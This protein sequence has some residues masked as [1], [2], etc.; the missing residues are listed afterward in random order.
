[1]RVIF[2]FGRDGVRAE[3][4]DGEIKRTFIIEREQGFEQA[5]FGGGLQAITRFGF[6][7]G[8]A[9]REHAQQARTG[10]RDE[11]FHAGGARGFDS[12]NNAAACRENI[13]I[14]HAAHL[15]LEFVGAV[16]RPDEMR[17]RVDKAG[18]E[19]ATARVESGFIGIGVFE[20]SGGA[21]RDDLFIAHND[22]AVFDDAK[23]AEGM[24][25]LRAACEGEELGGGVDE[26]VYHQ[27]I[28]YVWFSNLTTERFI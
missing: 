2:V 6:G 15:H 14:G 27:W 7:G 5:Q 21:D 23:R 26:H 13:E 18:H 12:G 19:N 20:F 3:E 4:G 11:R 25:A 8:G 9:V 17:V 16:A 22:R 1:M 28:I 24:S 10:L